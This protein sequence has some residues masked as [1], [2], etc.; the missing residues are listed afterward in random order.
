ME[1]G[2]LRGQTYIRNNYITSCQTNAVLLCPPAG[3]ESTY[4]NYRPALT[5]QPPPHSIC[6]VSFSFDK[7]VFADRCKTHRTS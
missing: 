5:P 2:C 3:S 4:A 6:T 7:A 1:G